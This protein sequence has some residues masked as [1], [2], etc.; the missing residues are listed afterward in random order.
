M[1]L[2]WA[3]LGLM[4]VWSPDTQPLC[5]VPVPVGLTLVFRLSPSLTSLQRTFL[6]V[7]FLV[8]VVAQPRACRSLGVGVLLLP[9]G[10][11]LAWLG[12]GV[13]SLGFDHPA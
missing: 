6:Q 2:A 11:L 5:I 7:D 12:F 4:V 1:S 3:L 8:G 13:K 9:C 10:L